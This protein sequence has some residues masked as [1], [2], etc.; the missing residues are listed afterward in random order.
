[1]TSGGKW[2]RRL[3]ASL[4]MTTALA[5]IMATSSA[6]AQ[7]SPTT[8]QAAERDFNIPAQ[9]LSTALALFGQQSGIQVSTDGDLV[10][11][12]STPGAQGR[13]APAT[14]LQRL[15]AGT[16]LT[17]GVGSTGTF[18]VQAAAPQAGSG[19][20]LQLGAVRIESQGG[21]PDANPYADP[22][23]PYK[24]DRL[25]SSKFT[26]PVLDTPRTVTVLTKEVLEDKE[27]TTLREIGR[28]TAGVTLGSGEGGNAFGDRF[29][30]R[31]FDARNDIFVDGVRDPG[32]SIRENFNTEQVEILRGPASSFAG[33]G[34]TGGA[35]NIVTKAA[36][37]T[38]FYKAEGTGGFS[39]AEK[40]GTFDVNQAISPMVDVRL[41]GMIQYSDV[42]GR[43]YTT[44]N[45]WGVAG[46]V[47]LKPTDNF[48]VNADYSHT[49][50]W[51]LPD[52]GVPYDQ[53]THRP[54][55]EDGISR[56]TYYGIVNRDFTNSTQDMG[57]LNAEWDVNDWLTLENKFRGSHSL[58]DY[59]GTI[60]ENPSATGVTAP[61]SSNA[62]HFSG[63]VQ[64]NAQSRYETADVLADQPQATVKFDTGPLKHTLV[65]GGEF[66]NEKIS[67][68]SYTGFTSELTT[69]PVAFTSSGAP[70]VSAYNPTH[71]LYGAGTAKLTGN[72]LKY[73]VD[74]NAGYLMDTANYHDFIIVNGG[75]RYDD[76]NIKASNNT[77]S[78]TDD[79]GITSYN[80]GIVVKPMDIA[81]VYFAYATA[82][83]PVG[84]ELDATS[85]SYGGF[86]ATQN[87]TQIYGPQRSQSYEVGTKWELFDRHLLASAAAFET[88]VSNARETAPA[89]LPGY[90]SGQIVAGASY[91]VQG[92]DFEAAGNIT[93]KWSVMGG[94]VVM[95]T[96]ITH[97]IVPTN[98]GLGLANIANESFNMLSK[99]Q[100][101]DWL[102]LG[103][104]SIYT[105]EIRGGSLL[106]AN[107]GVAYP[108]PPNPT[109]LP[110]H[111]RFDAFAETKI[112]EHLS[113]KLYV[114]NIFDKTYYDAFYQ[115]AQPFIEIAP[116]RS[117]S[118]TA[119]IK[120]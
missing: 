115:S 94:L 83:N 39:D 20:A 24:V 52:F 77:S 82:A 29:F 51:G 90:T 7:A 61:Y 87:A 71:Y 104:Q 27:A 80:A 79:S 89:N 46:A 64:L 9:S 22:S 88:D 30:I 95:K 37:D 118:L 10:K 6:H 86:A 14:A 81:S 63:Y 26:E 76:Y 66:S 103:G 113:M 84:D 11:N 3:G 73:N 69:G 2:A 114:Q 40:R 100:V 96:D 18:T 72:P 111:W 109:I 110:A 112:N 60:P 38:D 44:D 12:I 119:S 85:S 107:G 42:A 53:A 54:A 98:V 58:L 25:S 23:A 70:I 55:T 48:T 43:D 5:D 93:D 106:A 8:A 116:G 65:A 62:T 108:N 105:S 47:T 45:R 75:I 4:M 68:D 31:G 15:L 49:R 99:Y 41:N 57:T 36:Q 92:L 97:S 32:V 74:T 28:S 1:M 101:T 117:V 19:K 120:F 17:Y 21:A 78:R 33:R 59:I 67:I 50:L 34:T 35:I 91:R 16:G 102:E 56:D 13:M